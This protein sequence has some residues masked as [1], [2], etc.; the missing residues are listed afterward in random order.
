MVDRKRFGVLSLLICWGICIC[1]GPLQAQIAFWNKYGGGSGFDLGKKTLLTPDGSIVLAGEVFSVDGLGENNHSEHSDVVISRFT[2]QGNIFWTRTLGGSGFEHLNDMILTADGGYALIGT[3]TSSDGDIPVGGGQEDVWVARLDRKGNLVWS[4]SFGGSG[5]DKGFA[6]IETQSGDFI[7]GG[8][9]GSNQGSMRSPHHGALDSWIARLDKTGHIIWERHF[10]GSKNEKVCRIHE[11]A[12][13]QFLVINTSE[14]SDQ[15]VQTNLGR[16]DAWIF[17]LDEYGKMGWQISYG[18]EDNDDIHASKIDADGNLILVGTTFSRSGFVYRQQGRGDFWL[19]K[20]APDGNMIWSRTFGGSKPDG[21]N[22]VVVTYDGGYVVSGITQSR[23]GDVKLNQGYYDAWVLK[24]N[25]NGELQ[26]A[27]TFGFEA[28]DSFSGILEVPNGGF[29]AVGYSEQAAEGTLL[30]GHMGSADFWL[31]NFSDPRRAGVRPYVTPALLIGRVTA[32]NTGNPLEAEITLTDN[33]TLDSIN[34]AVSDP[35]DGEFAFMLP[36]HGLVSVNVLT[37]G[38]L[39]YGTDIL[40]DTL[41]SE[42]SVKQEII[43]QPIRIGSS[44]VLK[45]IYFK[46][47]KWDLLR[48]SFAELE[49]LISFLNLNPRVQIQISGHTDNTGNREQKMELSLRRARAV[50]KYLLDHGIPDW[51][52]KVKG[53]GLHRPIATNK[54]AAGRQKNR[55]VEFEIINK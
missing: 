39:F 23:D 45:N 24:V 50:K 25:G 49:R 13:G 29:L 53:F 33:I 20:L 7:I 51:R 40:T 52:M 55:R 31:C 42:T 8:A 19:L 2:T 48:T 34:G 18:G 16:K 54:T 11:Q 32:E 17:S 22:D 44:L 9:S 37:K 43:L 3:T 28:K 30:P 15:D 38:Y 46:T 12:P 26:W 41:L 1:S 36:T 4:K 10:G 6:I 27:R 5:N 47:G 21:A 35:G 14:S